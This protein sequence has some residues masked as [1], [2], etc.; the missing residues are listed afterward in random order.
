MKSLPCGFCSSAFAARGRTILAAF[1]IAAVFAGP[2]RGQSPVFT[3]DFESGKLDPAIWDT[4]TS[5]NVQIT[6]QQ[7]LVAHGKSALQIHYP[8]GGTRSYGFV[9][10]T[11][12]PDSVRSHCF[13][14]AY[15]YISPG[16]PGGHDV[17]LNA[18]TSGYPTSNFLEIGA[19]GGKNVMLS[20]QQNGA[21][22]PRGE[23]LIRG[24]PYPVGRWFCLEWEFTDHPDR[25]TVWIDGAPAGELA[26]FTVTPGKPTM[27]PSAGATGAA[28]KVAPVAP[29]TSTAAASEP[30]IP[31]TDLVKGFVDFS[32]G[33]RAWGRGAKEDF[34]LYYDDIAIDAKRIGPLE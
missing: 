14:R 31:G 10:A 26:D 30:A 3:E 5:G 22:V 33:F 28:A 13:G 27:L 24:S 6:V 17:L 9:V 8:K 25:T 7:A 4:R 18:G 2:L 19:S 23:T 15:V 11:H 34:D 1:G 32:F 20:Y 29:A 12:L 21:G 16:M